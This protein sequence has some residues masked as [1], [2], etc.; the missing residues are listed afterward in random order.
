MTREE[1]IGIGVAYLFGG[2]CTGYF[3]VRFKAKLDIRDHGSH[4]VGARN[5]GRVLGRGG[6]IVTLFGDALKGALAIIIARHFEFS[7]IAVSLVLVAVVVGHIWP[8][9]LNFRG[10]RGIATAFGGYLALDVQLALWVLVSTIVLLA[11]GRGVILSGLAAF[12]LLPLIA[13]VLDLSGHIVAAL[14]GCSVVIL[15]A[16]RHHL[17]GALPIKGE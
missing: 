12:A 11:L 5:V 4:G 8:F 1:I 6:F 13:F 14:A 10:G 15:Y 7:E 16:H 3:L 2:F 17:R 9:L